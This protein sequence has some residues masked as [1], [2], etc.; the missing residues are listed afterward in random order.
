M[1][2]P[3]QRAPCGVAVAHQDAT[4]VAEEGLRIYLAAAGLIIEQ[5]DRSVAVLSTPIRPHEGCAGGLPV[6]FLQDLDRR[7]VAMDERLRPEPQFQRVIDAG[8][9]PLARADHPVPQSAAADGNAGAV[10]GLGQ[11]IE[12]RAVDIFVDEREGQRR[13]RGDAARQGLRGHR[14]EDNR[15]V[16]AGAIAM[17]TGIFEPHIL[18]DFLF[19]S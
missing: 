5:H 6:L 9:M 13:S 11:A 12:R 17:A 3:C 18:Q 16:D 2:C 8:E 7:L 15:R 10:E 1:G 19:C 14:R 4:V